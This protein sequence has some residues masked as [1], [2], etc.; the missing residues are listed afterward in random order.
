MADRSDF[1][2]GKIVGARM[3]GVSI[4]NTAE[5]FGVAASTVSKVRTSFKTEEKTSSLEQNWKKAKADR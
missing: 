4:T 2:R 5:L 3:T 1:K